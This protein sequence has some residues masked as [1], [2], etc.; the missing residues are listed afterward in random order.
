MAVFGAVSAA[1]GSPPQPD[2]DDL[3]SQLALARGDSELAT[4]AAAAATPPPTASALATVAAE[5]AEHAQALA[6]EIARV[7]GRPTS[8]ATETPATNATG[9]Q[10][11]SP[12]S[13]SDVLAALRAS[14]GSAA[15]LATTSSGYRAGLLGSIAAACTAAETVALN[16]G[17]PQP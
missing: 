6:T 11:A 7:T 13:V 10:P 16:L 17:A 15:T 2:I 14:A 8:S 4:A 5:R 9:A 1:C 12:P 3:Q